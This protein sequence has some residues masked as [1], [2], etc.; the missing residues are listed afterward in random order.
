[1][2]PSAYQKTLIITPKLS[3]LLNSSY[4]L[5]YA[6]SIIILILW[7]FKNY[8]S[9]GKFPCTTAH[10]TAKHSICYEPGST[11]YT[12]FSFTATSVLNINLMDI[13]CFKNVYLLE[14]LTKS[15]TFEQRTERISRLITNLKQLKFTCHLLL[16]WHRS[17]S[18]TQ[19]LSL[20]NSRL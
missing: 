17:Q 6:C 8:F 3:E 19:S 18:V 9:K 4:T 11:K 20:S 1:M 5:F 13:L 2:Q 15:V 10:N 12:N 14:W 16:V 7:V